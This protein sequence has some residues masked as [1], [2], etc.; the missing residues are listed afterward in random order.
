MDAHQVIDMLTELRQ[1]GVHG[2]V[3]GGWG[4]D[5]LLGEQ[6]REHDDLDLVVP[7]DSIDTIRDRLRACGFA[8]ERDWLPTALA[9]R[10]ADGRAVDLHPVTPAPDGGGD[11]TQ[12]DGTTRWHYTAPVTG[13]IAGQVVLCCSPECQ[14]A[15]HLGYEPDEHDRADMTLLAQR[16]GL[17]LPP[18]Y[19]SG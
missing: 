6:T 19:G 13:H 9:M 10:H 5:A 7:A 4:V 8:V 3:D 11:Q 18:A 16:F 17:D 2:W 12:L 1:A 15:A 14:L